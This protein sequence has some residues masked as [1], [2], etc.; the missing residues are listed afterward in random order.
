MRGGADRMAG[1]KRGKGK[2][3]L[4]SREKYEKEN[5]TVSFRLDKET[6]Q[7]LKKHLA[8]TK[9][10]FADFVKDSLGREETMIEKRIQ[11]RAEQVDALKDELRCLR[12]LVLEAHLLVQLAGRGK[13]LGDP[14]CPRCGDEMALHEAKE[15]GAGPDEPELFT[16]ACVCGYF[17]D[18]YKGIDPSSLHLTDDDDG[19]DEEDA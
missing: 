6:Y 12:G 16:Y 17:I 11:A 15:I 1:S 13:G 14:F 18:S 2:S 8:G 7:R 5:P 19:E 10:S 3:K 9:C 4:P